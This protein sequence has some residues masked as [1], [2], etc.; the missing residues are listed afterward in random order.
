MKNVLK[1][2]VIAFTGLIFGGVSIAQDKKAE[3]MEKSAAE[4]PMTDQKSG[5]V[6]K[7][8]IRYRHRRSHLCG[9]QVGYADG[10]D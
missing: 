5:E 1:V 4:K 2:L 6:H 3:K 10:Q 9:S 7:G 8:E